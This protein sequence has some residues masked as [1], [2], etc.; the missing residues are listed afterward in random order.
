[1][2]NKRILIYQMFYKPIQLNIYYWFRRTGLR[3]YWFNCDYLK[4]K[5]S[6]ETINKIYTLYIPPGKFLQISMHSIRWPH[7]HPLTWKWKRKET[8]GFSTLGGKHDSHWLRFIVYCSVMCHSM[9]QCK[10][11]VGQMEE[12]D[13]SG[14]IS[15]SC[16]WLRTMSVDRSVTFPTN[17]LGVTIFKKSKDNTE[18]FEWRWIMWIFQDGTFGTR[19]Y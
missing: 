14:G 6:Q 12:V 16:L 2:E 7:M 3:P 19:S 11:G 13:G 18:D 1:M 4:V 10:V 8:E 9:I 17:I 15:K 5:I